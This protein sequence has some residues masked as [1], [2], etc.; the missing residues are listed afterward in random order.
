MNYIFEILGDCTHF[1]FYYLLCD[2]CGC[3]DEIN[4][5]L[6]HSDVYIEI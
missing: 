1:I 3:Y 6:D 2:Y 4:D 5:D